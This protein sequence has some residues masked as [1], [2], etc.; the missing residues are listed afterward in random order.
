MVKHDFISFIG[1]YLH[2]APA[3]THQILHA[4]MSADSAAS[5]D[6]HFDGFAHYRRI[7]CMKTTGNVGRGNILQNFFIVAHLVGAEAF[8]QITVQINLKHTQ[9]PLLYKVLLYIT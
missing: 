1:R 9:S 8:S 2:L 5:L 3:K 6:S 7:T 4:R